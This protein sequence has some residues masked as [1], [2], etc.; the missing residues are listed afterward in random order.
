L[1][2]ISGYRCEEV[3]LE[4]EHFLHGELDADHSRRLAEHLNACS[5]CWERAEFSRRLK[6][7]VRVKCQM[8][9]PE[10]VIRKIQGA[11]RSDPGPRML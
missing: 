2:E 1:S 3:L 11:I 6:Q 7:M 8:A 9:T 5:P 10:H 4:I